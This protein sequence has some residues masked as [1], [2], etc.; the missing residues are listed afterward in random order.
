MTDN[1]ELSGFLKFDSYGR[2]IRKKYK[3][4]V[5]WAPHYS[6]GRENSRNSTFKQY[7][8]FFLD[9]ARNNPEYNFVLMPHPEL[10]YALIESGFMDINKYEDYLMEWSNLDN[11]SIYNEGNYFE[12]FKVSD[13]LI[14]DSISYFEEYFP[15]KKPIIFLNRKDKIPFKKFENKIK[16]GL[17]IAN[18]RIDIEKYIK[19]ILKD[20]KD[21][22]Y[23][24]RDRL[25]EKEFYMKNSVC[26][27]IYNYVKS[28]VQDF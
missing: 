1:I 4:L 26:D 15:S 11:A 13:I 22:L 21:T 23:R 6:I 5:I 14:T 2:E 7:Y 24:K 17:Y 9:F 16:K 10:K 20:K 3:N 19:I 12:L 18:N 28:I 25:F 27:E 8:L